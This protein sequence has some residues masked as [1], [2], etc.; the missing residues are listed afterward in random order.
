MIH[1]VLGFN[2]ERISPLDDT[3]SLGYGYRAYNPL[4]MRFHCPDTLSPFGDG[5][6]NPYSY[7]TGDP[8]N[9]SAPSGHHSVLGWIGIGVGIVLGA[10]LTPVSG[11]SSLAVV[12]SVIS[13]VLAVE[14][15]VLAVA[16]QFVEPSDAQTAATMGWVAF[17][18]VIASGISSAALYRV[19]S[20]W[21][22]L[23]GLLRKTL[24]K[25]EIKIN[26][27]P[28]NAASVQYYK[29][30]SIDAKYSGD[31][32]TATRVAGFT[33]NLN[34]KE[35]PGLIVHRDRIDRLLFDFGNISQRDGVYTTTGIKKYTADEIIDYFKSRGIDLKQVS[36][37][38]PFHL[39]SCRAG[40]NDGLAQKLPNALDR[41][42]TVY[43]GVEKVY[44]TGLYPLGKNRIHNEENVLLDPIIY[45]PGSE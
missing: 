29:G 28:E 17:G 31:R 2:D 18:M 26:L 44:H 15:T 38:I 20:G 45:T 32:I 19:A 24:F 21:K 7:C 37:D 35:E 1:V 33:S 13:V 10:L 43:G 23:A 27:Q 41:P 16:Q 9:F 42:V 30:A 6:I 11:G 40:G 25:R 34:G 5:G 22:S 36:R 39:I 8:V 4:L 3:Y 12:L 14:S